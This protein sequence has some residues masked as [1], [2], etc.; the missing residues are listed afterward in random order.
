MCN[1]VL[2]FT[3]GA[4]PADLLMAKH[5]SQAFFIPIFVQVCTSIGGTRTRD[6]LCDTVKAVFP[7]IFLDLISGGST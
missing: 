2:R 6:P 5:D 1:G 7:A 4:T 3:S